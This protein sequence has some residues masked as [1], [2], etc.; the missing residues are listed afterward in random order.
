MNSSLPQSSGCFQ[1]LT[2]AELS[3]S[4]PLCE[5]FT[6]VYISTVLK[7]SISREAA[8]LSWNAVKSINYL[9]PQFHFFSLSEAALPSW[10]QYTGAQR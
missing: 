9:L 3:G 6:L 4:E 5:M 7:V 1:A 8:C 2:V 10:L